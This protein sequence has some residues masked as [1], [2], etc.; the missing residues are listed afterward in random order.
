MEDGIK[1]NVEAF[2]KCFDTESMMG[3]L[4]EALAKSRNEQKEESKTFLRNCVEEASID[5]VQ[6][7]H[8]EN[9]LGHMVAMLASQNFIMDA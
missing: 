6:H 5:M 4:D 8:V 7:G 9:L 2:T 1:V 3:A